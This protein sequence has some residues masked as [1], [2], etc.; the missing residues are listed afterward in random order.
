MQQ[1]DP[2]LAFREQFDALVKAS[3]LSVRDIEK[4]TGTRR[5]TL[6][7]WKNGKS[8]PQELDALLKVVRALQ[9]AAGQGVDHQFSERRWRALLGAAKQARDDRASRR[10]PGGVSR[11]R[12]LAAERRARS[13]DATTVAVEA[14]GGLRDLEVKP[15]WTQERDSYAGKERRAL[16]PDKQALVDGWEARRN[17]LIGTVQNAIL[18]IEDPDLRARLRQ[19][20]Q[21]LELWHEPM[22]HIRQGE[23]RTRFLATA[24]ALEALGAYRRGD[25]VPDHDAAYRETIG[26]VDLYFEGLEKFDKR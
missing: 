4:Q 26:Y 9:A 22:R 14:L 21:V 23:S 12:E 15:D 10:T 19:A 24:D 25:P 7:G 3:G 2:Q 1:Q 13:I 20:L 17:G 11:S 8:L 16:P 18:D 6:D 5:S